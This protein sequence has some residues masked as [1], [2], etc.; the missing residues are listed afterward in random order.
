[1]LEIGAVLVQ[2]L[3]LLRAVLGRVCAAVTLGGE[4][5]PAA[6][7]DA[8]R[9]AMLTRV[10]SAQR[11]R[12]A[13]PHHVSAQLTLGH[14]LAASSRPCL[15]YHTEAAGIEPGLGAEN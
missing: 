9:A 1:V 13:G 12:L 5:L 8:T 6:P 14:Q 10:S 4:A 3:K 2:K 7:L 15:K 11:A